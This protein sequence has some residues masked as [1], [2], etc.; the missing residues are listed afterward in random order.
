MGEGEWG[1]EI[2][3]T[4]KKAEGI[5]AVM[6]RAVGGKTHEKHRQNMLNNG[7][8]RGPAVPGKGKILQ[9]DRILENYDKI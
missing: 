8:G 5:R 6:A 7:A 9:T 2:P 3:N 1:E 4:A